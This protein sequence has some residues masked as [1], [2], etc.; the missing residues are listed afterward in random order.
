MSGARANGSVANPS[1]FGLLFFVLLHGPA[2]AQASPPLSGSAAQEEARARA[3]GGRNEVAL[4]VG[5]LAAALSYARSI[6]DPRMSV[7]AGVWGAW[8]PRNSFDRD[9]WEPIGLVVFGRYRPARWLQA[10]A[11]PAVA[12][13]LWA[14][15]CSDCSGTFAGVRSTALIGH[16]FVFI[17]P[18]A[19]VGRVSDERGGAD[20][21][22]FWGV[23]LRLVF[24]W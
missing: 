6:G 24:G 18:E 14:D 5:I 4:D 15:D 11:G 21:G 1:R 7:G 3:A 8:E 20:F 19:A 9:F 23:Q 10:E 22:A 17:G 13:Y 12:R 16:R 2:A